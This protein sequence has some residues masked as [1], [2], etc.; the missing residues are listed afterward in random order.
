MRKMIL[1]LI[2]LLAGTPAFAQ[3][4]EPYKDGR[5][6]QA[7]SMKIGVGTCTTNLFQREGFS[8]GQKVKVVPL[9]DTNPYLALACANGIGPGSR[10]ASEIG[11]P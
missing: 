4:V 11:H 10:P 9:Y 2:G 5:A 6:I 8:G 3:Q 7:A 1:V